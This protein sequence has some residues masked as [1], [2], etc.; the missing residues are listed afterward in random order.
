MIKNRILQ[1]ID[2]IASQYDPNNPKPFL[3]SCVKRQTDVSKSK[4]LFP[5][6]RVNRKG[7]MYCYGLVNY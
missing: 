5:G 6:R 2:L 3:Q 7:K 4:T 1:L